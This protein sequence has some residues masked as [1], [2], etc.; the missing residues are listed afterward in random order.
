M[1]KAPGEDCYQYIAVYVD[2][3]AII[4]TDPGNICKV[5]KEKYNFKLKGD[6]PIDYHLGCR[7]TKDPDGTLVSQN[8]GHL[9]TYLQRET[10][11]G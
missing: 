2:D 11:E 3:L 9:R 4:A 5:F 6:G 8:D 10:Q 7:Y 1:R